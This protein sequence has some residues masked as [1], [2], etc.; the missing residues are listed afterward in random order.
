MNYEKSKDHRSFGFCIIA[1][2]ACKQAT[3]MNTETRIAYFLK[4]N[5]TC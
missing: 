2:A 3:D 1:M 4:V 5:R